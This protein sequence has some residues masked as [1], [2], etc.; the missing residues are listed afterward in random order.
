MPSSAHKTLV[1]KLWKVEELFGKFATSRRTILKQT[2]RGACGLV[3]WWEDPSSQIRREIP[4]FLAFTHLMSTSLGVSHITQGS[5]SEVR[6][7][8]GS[9]VEYIFLI[10]SGQPDILFGCPMDVILFG[11]DRPQQRRRTF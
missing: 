5:P 1:K 10:S 6:Q 4:R 9:D 2:S 3:T 11:F 8:S 7:M